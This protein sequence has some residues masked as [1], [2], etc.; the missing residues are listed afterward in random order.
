MADRTCNLCGKEFTKPFWLRKH[1]ERKTSCALIISKEDLPQEVLDDP[2]L[3][4]KL[5]RFCGRVFSNYTSMRRHVRGSCNIAPNKKN[6]NSGMEILYEHTARRQ[7]AQIDEIREQNIEMLG[8]VRELVSRTGPV[9]QI[10]GDVVAIQIPGNA[11]KVAV[12]NTKK[13][14]NI[15]V[16]G[17]EDMSHATSE[18]IKAILDEALL[19]PGL[20]KAAQI[21][22]LKTAMLVF[23]DPEYPENHTCYLPNA[24]S[25]N[26]MVHSQNGWEIKPASLVLQPMAQKSV[27]CL[28]DKQPYTGADIYGPLLKEIADNEVK[29][30]SGASLRP[31]LVRNK[32][33]LSTSLRVLPVVG[34]RS[35][36]DEAV[37]DK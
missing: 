35:R 25:N 18:R 36:Q 1:F 30:T 11:N 10:G 7:Q 22:I 28:F 31:I 12:V 21:A 33:L 2:D 23:S 6:G 16:F 5:C 34:E 27:D 37:F 4:Q 29:Y 32:S 15:N 17:N 24:K 13:V 19:A 20:A 9:S 14:V 3:E 8:M 26:V